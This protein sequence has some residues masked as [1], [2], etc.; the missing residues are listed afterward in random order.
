MSQNRPDDSFTLEEFALINENRAGAYALLA[1]LFAKEVDND[2]LNQLHRLRFPLDTGNAKTDKGN[3]LIATYLSNIWAGSLME[4][5]VDYAHC[6]IGSGDDAFSAAYPYESVYTSPRRLMMQEARDEV[7]A[8][9][10]SVGIEKA[11][12]WKESEDHLAAELEFMA[13]LSRRTA[14]FCS[15]GNEKRA[16]ALLQVQCGFLDTHLS[17]WTGMLTADMRKFARTDFYRGLSLMLDGLIESDRELLADV[18]GSKLE[19]A[20]ASETQAEA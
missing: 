20:S 19:S 5:A 9:Y 14:D 7:L 1:R 15:A 11:E 3:T 10:R 6:F 13:V 12:S 2:T 8:I 16:T 4:L 18:L 17:A